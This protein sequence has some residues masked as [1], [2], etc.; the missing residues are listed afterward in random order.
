NDREAAAAG[1]NA[2]GEAVGVDR[3]AR[4]TGLDEESAARVGAERK[5]KAAAGVPAESRRRLRERIPGGDILA[6]ET[7]IVGSDS[8]QKVGLD[9]QPAGPDHDVRRSRD[10]SRLARA[11]EGDKILGLELMVGAVQTHADR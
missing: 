9:R 4:V 5:G 1:V 7:K 10:D 3:D 6:V 8:S 11:G 2:V